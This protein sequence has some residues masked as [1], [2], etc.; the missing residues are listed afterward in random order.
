MMGYM[1]IL[2]LFWEKDEMDINLMFV[3]KNCSYKVSMRLWE[4]PPLIDH[5]TLHFAVVQRKVL[6]S[7]IV[8]AHLNIW[9]FVLNQANV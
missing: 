3:G 8:F 9:R 7:F 6:A 1:R 2:T 5:R 4:T